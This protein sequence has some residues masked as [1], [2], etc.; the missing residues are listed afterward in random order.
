MPSKDIFFYGGLN[1]D[2]DL[3]FIPDGDYREAYQARGG[4]AADGDEGSIVS[5]AGHLLVDNPDLPA[6]NNLVMGSAVWVEDNSIIFFVSNSLGNDS[7]FK[8]NITTND[9]TLIITSH[10][11]HFNSSHKIYDARVVDGI[12]FWTDGF[13]ASYLLNP[14]GYWQFNPPR[15]LNIA[16]AIAGYAD[17]NEELFDVVKAPPTTDITPVYSTDSGLSSNKLYGKVFQFA[18]QYVYENSENS[19]WSPY[20]VLPVPQTQ[21]FV[22]GR[23][24]ITPFSENLMNISFPTGGELIKKIRVAVRNGNLGEFGVFI[25]L[26]KELDSIVDD[27]L[28]TVYYDGGSF[29]RP[30]GFGQTLQ[31]YDRVPQIAKTM[32]V[33]PTSQLAYG[34]IV[35]GY[36]P[37]EIEV[38]GDRVLK[39]VKNTVLPVC[40][41]KYQTTTIGSVVTLWGI[42]VPSIFAFQEGD[43]L[44]IQFPTQTT[45]TLNYTISS[46]DIAAVSGLSPTDAYLYILNTVGT[47]Y[48]LQLND[49]GYT[50]TVFPATG[51]TTVGT[52]FKIEITSETINTIGV[53]QCNV[54][55]PTRPNR[56]L[57]KGVTHEFGIQYYDRAL[58]SGGVLTSDD[59][60]ITVPFPF[61]EDRIPDYLADTHSPYYVSPRF[62]IN[63]TPPE[64]ARYYQIVTRK[65]N[66]IE[67]FQQR[68]AIGLVTDPQNPEL[69]KISLDTYYKSAYGAAINH[70]PQKGDICRFVTVSASFVDT[71]PAYAQGYVEVEVQKYSASEGEGGSECVWVTKFD[72]E[73]IVDE[74]GGFVFEIYTPTKTASTEPW[75]EIGL[76]KDVLNPY[77]EDRKHEGDEYEDGE[78]VTSP[79]AGGSTFVL[80][81]DM[82]MLTSGRTITFYSVST[83]FAATVNSATFNPAT[84]NTT[85]VINE[86][87]D[88]TTYLT[89]EFSTSQTDAMPAVIDFEFGDVYLRPRVSNRFVNNTSVSS[90]MRMYIEDMSVSD[91]YVS[92][93]T[94]YGRIAIEDVNFKRRTLQSVIHGG[95]YIDNT[96]NN[97]LC[98]FDFNVL[99]KVDLNEAYGSLTKI[100]MNGYTLK[101]LQARKETSI[102]IQKSLTLSGNGEQALMATDR[103]FGGVNP[104]DSLYGTVHSGSV[105][106]VDGQLFYYDFNNGVFVRSITN[107][108]QDIC[109]GKYKFNKFTTDMTNTIG[110]SGGAFAW[111]VVAAINENNSE[112]QF[113]AEGEVD[114][115][116]VLF[117]A[118]FNFDSDRWKT[119]LQFHPSWTENLG[120][121]SVMWNDAD[122][123][124]C[125]DGDNGSYL[126]EDLPFIVRFPFNEAPQYVKRPLAIGLKMN[127][128]PETLVAS[129]PIGFN[130][131]FMQSEMSV[132]KALENG[133]WTQYLRDELDVNVDI[134][135]LATTDLARQ[136]GRALRGYVVENEVSIE[137]AGE[138]VVLN[139]ARVN[140]VVSESAQ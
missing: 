24:Y 77:T 27:T 70:T 65:T 130:Y 26:D 135:Y 41:F 125:D 76:I 133:F 96:N 131:P 54:L 6:G 94:N 90:L 134:P 52:G 95:A 46:D 113:Y 140:W 57:K 12:L 139:S 112:Y 43:V 49:L 34:N 81:G 69:Y 2:D 30:I 86:T 20:T 126:G 91:Y 87:S 48:A 7:I 60:S 35:E 38:T 110:A 84:G 102:Y 66:E 88:G 85:V 108:Q 21:E 62:T 19:V 8:Y 71:L 79:S 4:N 3:R 128:A 58:R 99:N 25:E 1:T 40:S 92:N 114:E 109:N 104:Y 89:Y 123:Y 61:Y 117:G 22:S 44:S 15:M 80:A 23:N 101:C 9:F 14:D 56:S 120:V 31:N 83:S 107:G 138:K 37:I 115:Q 127:I 73:T 53:K 59:M 122:M 124:V 93:S 18:I 74:T 47:D 72:Y 63:H 16:N 29:L 98:S 11:L 5:M 17:V 67:N 132:F 136:N 103:T 121:V 105:K 10:Y 118:V 75:F 100:I 64:W 111:E 39:E 28:Y 51:I 137:P 36:D 45:R 129:T 68:L 50:G 78:V 106:V 97:N 55:I 32:E 116:K 82:T 33:L 119:Y 13:F 42:T